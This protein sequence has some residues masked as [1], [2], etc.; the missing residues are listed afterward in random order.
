M[1]KHN[2]NKKLTPLQPIL[3]GTSACAEKA[4][5]IV[6]IITITSMAGISRLVHPPIIESGALMRLIVVY[7]ATVVRSFDLPQSLTRFRLTLSEVFV[8]LQP[9][10]YSQTNSWWNI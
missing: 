4:F 7:R 10:F 1:M 2:S 8:I 6:I 3:P 9:T 5:L